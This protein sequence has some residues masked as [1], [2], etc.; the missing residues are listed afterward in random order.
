MREQMPQCSAWIDN[1]REA[2]GAELIDGQIKAGMKGEAVFFASENGIELGTR[3][4]RPAAAVS[5]DARGV[6]TVRR[7][8]R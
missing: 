1:L 7:S 8:V 2:F 3:D 6:A 4:D 5:F